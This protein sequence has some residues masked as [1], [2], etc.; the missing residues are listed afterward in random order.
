MGVADV[1][2]AGLVPVEEGDQPGDLV[3]DVTEAPG[4]RPVPVD[5]QRRAG[6]R[7]VDEVGDDATVV[8]AHPRAV[9]VEDPG[10]PSLQAMHARIGHGERLGEAL[11]L[12]VARAWPDRVHVAVVLLGLRV[13]ERIAVDLARRGQQEPGPVAVGQVEELPRAGAADGE[14]LDRVSEVGRGR[15]RA[16]EVHDRVEAVPTE[17]RQEP[18][19]QLVETGRGDVTFDE[20]ERRHRREVV[21]VR[22]AAGREVVDADDEIATLEQAVDEV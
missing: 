2:R 19:E 8:R 22:A 1:H 17:R 3:V 16:G 12:V 5:R 6:E 7:L 9:R 14:G 21:D 20:S 11:R 13:L 4:L 15:R 18:G 10:D